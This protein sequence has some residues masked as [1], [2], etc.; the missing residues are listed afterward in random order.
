MFKTCN[1][2]LI[3]MGSTPIPCGCRVEW[4]DE[5]TKL[6]LC[7]MHQFHYNIWDGTEEEFVKMVV[8]PEA[9]MADSRQRLILRYFSG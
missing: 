7:G 9:E 3:D 8:T 6:Y 5:G 4:N 2:C 1:V